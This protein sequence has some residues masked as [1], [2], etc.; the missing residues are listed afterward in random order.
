M[1]C[2]MIYSTQ[3]TGVS[4]VIWMQISIWGTWGTFWGHFSWLYC[5]CQFYVFIH[6]SNV[7]RMQKIVNLSSQS[8]FSKFIP[9]FKFQFSSSPKCSLKFHN[10]RREIKRFQKTKMGKRIKKAFGAHRTWTVSSDWLC[11]MLEYWTTELQKYLPATAS[12]DLVS[13]AMQCEC[14]ISKP[15]VSVVI[16]AFC[17]WISDSK[18]SINFLSSIN[19]TAWM[20]VNEWFYR[21]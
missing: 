21:Y 1:R 4:H 6:L 3:K 2:S 17:L 7:S 20:K 14:R 15:T 12:S 5:M 11:F 10:K 8:F 19:Q 18:T 9:W 13:A 16:F